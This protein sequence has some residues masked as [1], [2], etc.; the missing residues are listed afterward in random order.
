MTPNTK[1]WIING[2]LLAG[3]LG[4]LA[5]IGMSQFSGVDGQK[6]LSPTPIHT[7]Q[8]RPPRPGT[9]ESVYVGPASGQPDLFPWI[10]TTE[11]FR[12]LIT[13]SPTPTPIPPPAA[14]TPSLQRAV[15]NWQYEYRNKRLKAYHFSETGT[16]KEYDVKEDEPLPVPDPL[17]RQN[18]QVKAKPSGKNNVILETPDGQTVEFSP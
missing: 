18:V 3:I 12:D 7:P 13:P 17:T 8:P 6:P 2:V 15:K 16:N 11:I 9:I 5:V 1:E 4:F 10:G 14:Q